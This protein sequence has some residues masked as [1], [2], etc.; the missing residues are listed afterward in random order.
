MV[1]RWDIVASGGVPE[2]VYRLFF[3]TI[4]YNTHARIYL[5]L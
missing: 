4:G 5:T 2:S 1:P 3:P